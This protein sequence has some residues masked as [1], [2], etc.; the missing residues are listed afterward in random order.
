M[1]RRHAH[2][3]KIPEMTKFISASAPAESRPLSRDITNHKEINQRLLNINL[4]SILN[5]NDSIEVKLLKDDRHF[6]VLAKT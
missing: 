4:R 3:E 6:S 5:K 2:K 1:T